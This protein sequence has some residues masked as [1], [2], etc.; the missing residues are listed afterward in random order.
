MTDEGAV[1][2]FLARP[3]PLPPD[4]AG[5]VVRT[6]WRSIPPARRRAERDQLI[7]RAAELLPG[8]P[9]TKAKA[10]AQLSRPARRPQGFMTE[11]DLS[12]P[13][14]CIAAAM[15]IPQASGRGLSARQ[16]HRLIGCD[17]EGYQ[18]RR[19]RSNA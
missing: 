3:P 7:R 6:L 9:W 14:G 12:T 11:P 16:I 17:I 8:P 13:A 2:Q 18:C 15:L 1:M 10:L 5:A 19:T 4:L